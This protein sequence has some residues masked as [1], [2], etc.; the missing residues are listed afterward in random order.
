MTR[1]A[2]CLVS[3]VALCAGAPFGAQPAPA[4]D[5]TPAQTQAAPPDP[6]GDSNAIVVTGRTA[7]PTGNE[8]FDEA[9]GISRVGPHQLYVEALPCFETPV[10]PGIFG[11]K[12][13]YAAAMIDRIRA[14]IARLHIPLAG[15]KCSPNL[16]VVFADDGRSVLSG[17][18]RNRP[19]I[20]RLVAEAEQSEMLSDAGPAHVWNNIATRWTGNGPPPEKGVKASVWGQIDRTSMPYAYDIT[21]SLVVF[22]RDAVLGMTLTQLADYATMRGLSHTR[23]AGDGQPMATILSLFDNAGG[24]PDELMRFDVGYLKS[25]YWWKANASAANKLVDV[26]RWADKGSTDHD[27]PEAVP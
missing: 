23:P 8:V 12:A 20:F 24:G 15:A 2:R 9:R 19:R 26:K 16:I 13:D 21:G 10:C 5:A 22:D 1:F 11:L 14:T 3:M 25:L 6:S 18:K 4:R 7:E 17:L 27:T